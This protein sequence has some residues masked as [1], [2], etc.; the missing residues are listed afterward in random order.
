MSQC[1]Q[2]AADSVVPQW[3]L[4]GY[5]YF[6]RSYLFT[7]DLY[8]SFFQKQKQHIEDRKKKKEIEIGV[9]ED[10]NE[11]QSLVEASYTLLKYIQKGPAGLV[12][13]CI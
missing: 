1:S 4:W 3:E 6:N 11:R 7:N 9:E 12:K 2:D 13:L 10:K 8:T 5:R